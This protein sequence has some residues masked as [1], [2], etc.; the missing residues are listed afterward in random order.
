MLDLVRQQVEAI[1]A[2]EGVFRLPKALGCF[3]AEVAE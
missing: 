3:V 1:I 2:R